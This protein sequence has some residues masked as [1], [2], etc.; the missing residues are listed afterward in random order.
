[1]QEINLIKRQRWSGMWNGVVIGMG[2]G[3][4]LRGEVIGIFPLALGIVMEIMQRKRLDR[5]G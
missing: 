1:M 5:M 3:W 4:L 2:F